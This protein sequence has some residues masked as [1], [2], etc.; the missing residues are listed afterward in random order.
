MSRSRRASG[1]LLLVALALLAFAGSA[2]AA[3]G[4]KRHCLP[5]E[6]VQAAK[7]Y[8]ADRTGSVSFAVL[9]E[10]GRLVG[11]HRF[12]VHYSASVVKVMLLTAYLRRHGVR[13]DD[14]TGDERHL[15]GPMIKESNNKSADEVYGI[16]GPEGLYRVARDAH[17]RHFTTNSV[18]GTSEITAGDQARFI[19]HLEKYVPKRHRDYALG[20]MARVKDPQRWGVPRLRLPGWKVRIKGG[21][22]P[23]GSG[24]G[25]RVNQVARI[26]NGDRQLSLAILT[27]DQTDYDYGRRTIEGVAA[28]LLK[29]YTGR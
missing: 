17:M 21:W 25:W 8:A 22:S 15:L 24:G 6:R 9:D 20:L 7:R 3:T 16:V 13:H 11:D 12:R 5:P 23:Q 10:C 19:G 4:S 28:H 18:W 26:E 2:G 14:L 27:T 1:S 29:G